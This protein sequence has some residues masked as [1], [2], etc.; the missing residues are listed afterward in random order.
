MN[1]ALEKEKEKEKGGYIRESFGCK[2][3]RESSSVGMN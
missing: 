2:K 3:V 1:C